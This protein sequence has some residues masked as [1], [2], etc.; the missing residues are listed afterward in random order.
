MLHVDP[1]GFWEPCYAQDLGSQ[2]HHHLD[3]CDR[4]PYVSCAHSVW[5]EEISAPTVASTHAMDSEIPKPEQ[6][7]LL[8]ESTAS[9]VDEDGVIEHMAMNSPFRATIQPVASPELVEPTASEPIELHFPTLPDEFTRAS[10]SLSRS[11]QLLLVRWIISRAHK[12]T[13]SWPQEAVNSSTL[14]WK[15]SHAI[16]RGFNPAASLRM[17]PPNS[18]GTKWLRMGHSLYHPA[19][20]GNQVQPTDQLT[21]DGATA[22]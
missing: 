6:E 12:A 18:R 1:L 10:E 15:T 2:A 19:T 22:A 9:C 21:P 17:A 16:A 8:V 14:N 5:I 13:M 7:Q 20:C 3:A 11:Y 4:R